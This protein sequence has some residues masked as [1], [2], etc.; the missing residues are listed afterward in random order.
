[1][2]QKIAWA[3]VKNNIGIFVLISVQ[4]LYRDIH[5]RGKGSDKKHSFKS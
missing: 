2:S 4:L 1:M 5:L 3:A